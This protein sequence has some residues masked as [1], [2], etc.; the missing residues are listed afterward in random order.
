MKPLGNGAIRRSDGSLSTCP[1]ECANLRKQFY[2]ELLNCRRQ[3]D[4]SVWE[5][6]L[7]PA[8]TA[9]DTAPPPPTVE[10]VR[11]ALDRL[12]NC[13]AAGVCR[14]IPEMLK[15][16]GSA[17]TTWLHRI[18]TI[19]WQTCK[20]PDDW[21]RSLLVPVLKKGD[22]TVLDNFRGISLQSIAGKVY[23]LILR[24]HLTDWAES[25]L[26]EAR[27]GFRRGRGCNNAIFCL[28]TLYEK[29]AKKH[30]SVYTLAE[31]P[32]S[33][34]SGERSRPKGSTYIGRNAYKIKTEL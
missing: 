13:K 16:G 14:I 31:L 10:Q 22:P 2:N 8:A 17:T 34:F 32:I 33:T 29:A 6:L 20:A 5:E 7:V 23:S 28:K 30:K 4:A 15:Y 19:V 12:K 9:S 18:I 21:K 24:S 27:C 11:A 3:I 1:V 25:V 26:S